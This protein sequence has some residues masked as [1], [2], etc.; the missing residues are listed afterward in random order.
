MLIDA[1]EFTASTGGDL[2]KLDSVDVKPDGF[3]V[4]QMQ[5]LFVVMDK[6]LVVKSTFVVTSE[7]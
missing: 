5:V 7:G 1:V 4:S 2:D 3:L 6:E